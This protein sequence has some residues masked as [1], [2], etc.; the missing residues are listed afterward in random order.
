MPSLRRSLTLGFA[1]SLLTT[2]FHCVCCA[3][4]GYQAMSVAQAQATA[5][6]SIPVGNDPLESEDETGCIC[7]G[8]VMIC[9]VA[10]PAVDWSLWHFT[11]LAP[12]LGVWA[13]VLAEPATLA[14][15]DSLRTRTPIAGRILRALIS[16]FQC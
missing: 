9:Q 10:A 14:P 6:Q 15:I 3:A 5:G 16:S 11:A 12:E 2:H 4:W 1:V 8:A 13:S 7:R